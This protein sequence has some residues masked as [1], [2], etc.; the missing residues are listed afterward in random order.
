MAKSRLRVS[1]V[2]LT[3]ADATRLQMEWREFTFRDI[4][5]SRRL[6]VITVR[7][8]AHVSDFAAWC[9]CEA[10]RDTKM[11]KIEHQQRDA[12]NS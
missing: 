3:E 6:G 12:K 10:R 5:V 9:A 4:K 8:N 7:A 1:R 2:A 11:A